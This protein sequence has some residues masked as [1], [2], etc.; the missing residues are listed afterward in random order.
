[1]R[2]CSLRKAMTSRSLLRKCAMQLAAAGREDAQACAAELVS[3]RTGAALCESAEA[4]AASR[5]SWQLLQ[6]LRSPVSGMR[7]AISDLQQAI[8]L[9]LACFFAHA[10]AYPASSSLLAAR[11]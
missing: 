7:I 6:L 3:E 1:M 9:V 8:T 10:Y 5:A 2:S 11:R 4:R